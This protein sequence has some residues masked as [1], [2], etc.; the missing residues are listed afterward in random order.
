MLPISKKL[1]PWAEALTSRVNEWDPGKL[2]MLECVLGAGDLS[3][4]GEVLG[5]IFDSVRQV[6]G[7]AHLVD[8]SFG[9]RNAERILCETCGNKVTHAREYLEQFFTASATSLQRQYRVCA[10]R[11]G[12]IF[13]SICGLPLA[14]IT[15][16]A[17]DGDT[18]EHSHL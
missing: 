1:T 3:D 12:C 15:G 8:E 16:G 5:E 7:G 9:Q 13:L 17:L 6:P 2:K 4:A 14:L 10:P 11:V 18:Y